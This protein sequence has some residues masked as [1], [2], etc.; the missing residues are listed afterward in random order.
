ERIP[1]GWH[2]YLRDSVSGTTDELYS[3]SRYRLYLEAGDYSNRFSVVFKKEGVTPTP[4]GSSAI[5]QAYSINGQLFGY[6]DKVPDERCTINV[7]N[8]QGQV[9]F[10]KELYSNGRH[11][12]GSQYSN[13]IYIVNFHTKQQVVSKKVF[14]H[15]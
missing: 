13:G 12:L 3:Q 2:I 11:L 7:I 15:N 6:F 10:R 9:L 8:L 5:F 14:I 4:G 1:P